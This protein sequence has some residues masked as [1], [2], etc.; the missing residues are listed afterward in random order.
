MRRLVSMEPVGILNA[1]TMNVRMNVA[2]MNATTRD[3]RYSR[4]T[5]FLCGVVEGAVLSGVGADADAMNGHFSREMVA[6]GQRRV[7]PSHR[8]GYSR[9]L[10]VRQTSRTSAGVG[11]PRKAGSCGRTRAASL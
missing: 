4:A 3:S 1:C 11:R 7:V 5:D 8:R 10:S 6:G 9:C 2:R